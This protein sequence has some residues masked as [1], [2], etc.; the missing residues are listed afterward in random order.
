M[1]K[2]FFII[3]LVSA[4]SAY[5]QNQVIKNGD[6]YYFSN[7]LV[8][9]LEQPINGDALGKMSIPAVL[10]KSFNDLSIVDVVQKF[11]VSQAENSEELELQKIIEIEYSSPF[12]P[13]FVAS[14]LSGTQGVEWAEPH[15]VYELQYTVNDPSYDLQWGLDKVQAQQAWDVTKGNPNVIIAIND[16]G[17]D[18]DHSDLADNIWWNAD[19]TPG[20]GIDD[21]NNGYTDDVRGWDFGGLTGTPDNDPMEDRPDH[22]THVAGIACAVTDN[23]FGIA[24]LGFNCT[25]MPVKTAQ[26]NVRNGTTALISHGYEGIYYAVD[27]GANII[28]CSWGGS[29]FSLTGQAVIDYAVSKGVLIV[30]AAGNSGS[31]PIIYPS[32]YDGVL[33]VGWTESNDTKSGSSNYGKNLDVLA[34]GSNIYSTWQD[35][36]YTSASGTSAASPLTAGLAALVKSQFPGYTPHQI[37]E[38]IRVNAD[39]VYSLNSP[40]YS[41]LLGKG[42]INAYK[43]VSNLNSV[44]VRTK[45]V[46]FI[47]NGNNNGVFEPGEN[48]SVHVDFVNYLNT[49]SSLTI[50]LVS[51][52]SATALGNTSFSVGA[53]ASGQSFSN[54]GNEFTFTVNT[55]APLNANADFLILFSDG[56]YQDFEWITTVVNS[57]FRTQNVNDISLTI[58]SK[59]S[60]AYNDYPENKQGTGFQYQGGENLLFEGGLIY[61]S[62]V[63][64]VVNSVRGANQD[65]QDVDFNVIVPFVLNTPGTVADQQGSAK[66]NDGNAG[67]AKLNIETHCSTYSY[68]DEPFNKFIIFRYTF[69]NKTTAA[70]SNFYAGQ[71]L[72]WDVSGDNYDANEAKYD[73][74]GN[75]GYAFLPPEYSYPTNVGAALIS[76]DKYNFYPIDNTGG[77]GGIQVY[78]GFTDT[79]KW[80]ALTN[81]LNKTSAGP[82]DISF[83]ISGG[84]YTIP[85]GG[86]IN[87]A[88]VIAA[89][90]NLE[91]L[92]ESINQSRIKYGQ[93]PVGIEEES[94]LTQP[95]K[96]S[97]GQNYP[98]PFNPTTVINY[99]LPEPGKVQ[100]KIY[101][102]LGCEVTT[103]INEEKPAGRYQVEFNASSTAGGLTSGVYFYEL[104]T[105]AY[106]AIK[107]MMILK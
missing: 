26:D 81:G 87:V 24:G 86:S 101:D 73:A 25:L 84:P 88:F 35:N 28:N 16:T 99:Q 15:F 78:D 67:T 29:G 3:I 75:F 9:K 33:S 66:Y 62:D 71:F 93:I 13:K 105:A 8:V 48:V 69:N 89:G 32:G 100:I 107:K 103:L 94:D 50:T 53:V 92:R 18:W 61:G 40:T 34:P 19:E 45:K 27:N 1:K 102:I 65:N 23:M 12:D 22:G 97:L 58:T 59:G 21:D 37:A 51:K 96:F 72:D 44:S 91:D 46:E 76:D 80:F 70:I 52:N 106:R 49:T 5:A 14:K 38:Q 63:D 90:D 95:L 36:S 55:N 2:I 98:N 74:A 83:V 30:A 42:R 57:S 6:E 60:F 20:N 47:D 54:T 79:E 41:Y 82:Q 31:A 56:D 64:H 10:S 77:D 68:S 85:A 104:K 43:A 17:I 39:D 7:K 11:S 4:V